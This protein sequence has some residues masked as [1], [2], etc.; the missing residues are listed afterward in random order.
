MHYA[1]YTFKCTETNKKYHYLIYIV[2]IFD[3]E[4]KGSSLSDQHILSPINPKHDDCLFWNPTLAKLKTYV[5]NFRKICVNPLLYFGLIGD[6][7]C[8]SEKEK[9]EQL[10]DHRMNQDW[11]Y[12]DPILTPLKQFKNLL[13]Q[14]SSR[15]H[16]SGSQ[17]SVWPARGSKIKSGILGNGFELEILTHPVTI[18]IY[19]AL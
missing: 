9:P 5:L 14:I 13:S 11:S 3:R 12:F 4:F 10:G 19:V 17:S 7:I 18:H 16:E 1:S 8:W 2:W 15:G 6:K